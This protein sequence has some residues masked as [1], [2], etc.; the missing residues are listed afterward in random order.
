[1]SVTLSKAMV[2]AFAVNTGHYHVGC[3]MP[4]Y[5]PEGEVMCA[6]NIDD[7]AMYLADELDR[8]QSLAEDMCEAE[9]EEQ[10][11]QGSDCC[12]WCAAYYNIEAVLV[13]IR[14]VEKDVHHAIL[15]DGG[16]QWTYNPPTGA[17]LSFWVTKQD[18]SPNTCLLFREQEGDMGI[19]VG[20]DG[21]EVET[22]N[23]DDGSGTEVEVHC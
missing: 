9:T 1:M 19:D 6:L 12:D 18:D 2:K 10:K 4:G 21:C 11:D 17:P 23:E 13:G 8:S 7:A 16:Y 5:L 3:N 14:A 15:R 22:F 20:P